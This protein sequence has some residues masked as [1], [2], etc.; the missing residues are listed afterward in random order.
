MTFPEHDPDEAIADVTGADAT[1]A[2]ASG[3]DVIERKRAIRASVRRSRRAR[4]AP[5]RASAALA[6]AHHG[7]ELVERTGATSV[8]LFL[9]TPTEPSTRRLIADLEA[10]DVAV[11]LPRPVSAGEMEWVRSGGGERRTPGLGTPEPLGA[12]LAPGALD[13]AGVLF[14]PAAAIDPRGGRLGWGGGY[15]DRALAGHQ[16]APVVAIVFDDDLRDDLP[17][18]PHDVPVDAVLTPSGLRMHEQA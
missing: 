2:E 17:V 5:E 3:D 14:V 8:T 7:V 18:E 9:S 13:E 15:Y 11:L 12:A 10:R 6:I 16:T 1:S 4:T